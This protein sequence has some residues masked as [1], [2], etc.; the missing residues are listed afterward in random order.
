[1]KLV[2]FRRDLRI[3]DN[4]ALADACRTGEPVAAIYVATP[5][6]WKSHFVS[7]RQADLIQ[8]RLEV[9]RQELEALN[10]PMLFK[11][12]DNFSDIPVLL[13]E[14]C[15]QYQVS[16]VYC[17]RDY[18]YDEIDRDNA[19]AGTLS[20]TRIGFHVFDGKCILPP[21]SVTTGAGKPFQV[22]TPFKKAW[23]K[24]I[25]S[26]DYSP[27]KQPGQIAP[28]ALTKSLI[29]EAKEIDLRYWHEDSLSWPVD[30]NTI[31]Q[32]L[33]DYCSYRVTKYHQLRDI[34]SEPAT[35]QLS[36]YLAIGAISPR[37]CLARLITEHRDCF[38]DVKEGPQT[39]LSEII[40]R[41]FYQHVIAINPDLCKGEAFLCW[42]THISW[43]HDEILFEKWK[44]GKTG[45]PIVDAGMRQLNETGWMHN[46][47]RMIV[48]SFLVKDLHIDWRWGEQYFMSKLIDG[49][50]ASNNGGWQW[51]ASVGLDAQPYF[52]I[53]NPFTQSKKFDPEGIFIRR[54]VKELE[55][56][57]AKHIH[58]P[59]NK[60]YA[61]GSP[62]SYP[63]PI[64]DHSLARKEAL[65]FFEAAKNHK[66]EQ[67]A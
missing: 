41:E 49:D 23:L 25:Q 22:F 59:Y 28:T 4:P 61:T 39:W 12:V 40:W 9:I 58:E 26:T 13:A 50:F 18:E 45:V 56:V 38:S 30:D 33:R 52:R 65:S 63:K 3:K 64:V 2:W 11:V 29:D 19:V 67:R 1:M 36:A 35:S 10:I 15:Q 37:Q 8:R 48:A 60:G 53:F 6:Q 5:E 7:P 27:L 43:K 46:R 57:S 20:L 51:S 17:N 66:S 32:R 62:L 31:I 16:D 55:S 14:I 47:L 21:G 42:E 54:W 24:I 34:P 44:Q